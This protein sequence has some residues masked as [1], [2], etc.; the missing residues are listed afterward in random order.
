MMKLLM[1]TTTTKILVVLGLTAFCSICYELLI[2]QA[3][4][5]TYGGTLSAYTLTIGIFLFSMGVGSL[6]ASRVK[7]TLLD[8]EILITIL[9]LTAP[10]MTLAFASVP[11][12]TPLQ[13]AGSK[14]LSYSSLAALGV[15]TG[16]EIPIAFKFL[17]D[18]KVRTLAL[19]VDYAGSFA[20]GLIFALIMFPHFG[21]PLSIIV[22]SILNL[23][24]AALIIQLGIGS[25]SLRQKSMVAFL[26]VLVLGLAFSRENFALTLS[27]FLA[28][29]P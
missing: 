2:G 27:G 20:A 10:V 26:A 11:Q 9:G 29:A 15:L 1:P 18:D 24:V 16:L 5:L 14:L 17:S 21:L 3:I 12:M 23:A 25:V 6:V 28:S 22:V 13:L 19:A 4:A 8:V 7:L